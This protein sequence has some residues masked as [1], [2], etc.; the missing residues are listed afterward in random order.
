MYCSLKYKRYNNMQTVLPLLVICLGSEYCSWQNTKLITL[1]IT[2]TGSNFTTTNCFC[3][4]C[5]LPGRTC[6][7]PGYVPAL[8][9]NVL[10]EAR[11]SSGRHSLFTSNNIL[12][13]GNPCY[14]CAP[15][16]VR[17]LKN[18]PYCIYLL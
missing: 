13:F 12:L 18:V 14:K 10:S 9:T 3:T 17:W 16:A 1:R 4:L 7:Y 6:G 15:M 8:K 2:D 5:K 11:F